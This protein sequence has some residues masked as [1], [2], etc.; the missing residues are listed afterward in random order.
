MAP[1]PKTWED[2]GSVRA[3]QAGR[4]QQQAQDAAWR[5][6]QVIKDGQTL[7][8]IAA[9]TGT[10]VPDLLAANP[11]VSAPR[12]GMVLN[13]PGSQFNLKNTDRPNVVPGSPEWRA[14]NIGGLPS[15]AALGGTTTNPGGQ[16]SMW[17]GTTPGYNQQQT[18]NTSFNNSSNPFS[19]ASGKNLNPYAQYEYKPPR[20]NTPQGPYT[21]P[22][23]LGNP[24]RQ[25]LG[26]PVQN[27]AAATP[28]QPIR[29]RPFAGLPMNYPGGF[30]RWAREEMKQIN[31]PTYTPNSMALAVLERAGMIVKDKA[32]SSYG[33]GGYGRGRGGG[34]RGG[35]GSSA[36]RTSEPR[37]P[38]FSSGSGNMGLINWRI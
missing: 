13:I 17:G 14:Q 16:V 11:D 2:R 7:D 5:A 6:Q 22:G 12:T 15:N 3:R 31:S 19:N 4:R 25:T 9:Q 29:P 28:A 23:G 27:V 30:M 36:Q 35:G 10:T 24:Q 34:G 33:G 18:P 26:A 1:R 21:V 32:P 38:A 8:Q 37:M 20:V